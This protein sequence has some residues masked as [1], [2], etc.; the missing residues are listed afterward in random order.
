M[1]VVLGARG[2]LGTALTAAAAASAPARA[3]YDDWGGDGG[4]ARAERYFRS[5]G[6]T[7]TAYVTVGL[8]DPSLPPADHARVNFA[9]AH[10]AAQGA[11]AAGW[12]AVTFG[13]VLE[14]IVPPH[15][16][17]AYVA[18]KQRL[19]EAVA[20]LAAAGGDVAHVRLH[21][22]YGGGP[23]APF[24]FLGQVLAALRSREPF[25][26]SPG[27]QL[28]EYHHVEDDA[29][30]LVALDGLRVRGVVAL[31]H[32]EMLALRT[33]AEA[34]FEAFGCP[35]RLLVGAL[36][37]PAADNFE[38]RFPPLAGVDVR[39]RATLPAVIEYLRAC[40]AERSGLA[41]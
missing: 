36:P 37:G 34:V 22:L 30:A 8:T 35:E 14:A 29:R 3:L 15:A 10:H 27:H 2:R 33:L 20:A 28:R 40:L 9:L 39:F 18:S 31:S 1:N 24:M 23:P 41:A 11:L 12:R 13:T 19:A 38:Q 26:M 7:G 25:R 6:A 21:T 5:Q 32:G 17:N 4:A 16:A